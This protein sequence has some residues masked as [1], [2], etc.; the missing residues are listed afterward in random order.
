MVCPVRNWLNTAKAPRARAACVEDPAI[1]GAATA[2]DSVAIATRTARAF[3][4]ASLLSHFVG[5]LHVSGRTRAQFI[6]LATPRRLLLDA[7]DL[8]VGEPTWHSVPPA[9]FPGRR[10][11]SLP[12]GKSYTKGM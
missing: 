11:Q 2:S 8:A 7:D 10:L 3:F 5:P 12:E 4:I 9:K 6:S 1:A